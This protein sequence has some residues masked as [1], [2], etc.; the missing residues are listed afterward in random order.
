MPEEISPADR[1]AEAAYNAYCE[2]RDWES[3]RGEELPRWPAVDEDIKIAWRAAALS[4]V[5]AY[6]TGGK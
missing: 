6:E 4:V 3:V 5:D 2:S 1:L